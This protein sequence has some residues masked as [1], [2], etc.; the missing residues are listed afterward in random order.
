MPPLVVVGALILSLIPKF[1]ALASS[2]IQLDTF[3][4][5][6]F[7]SER[8]CSGGATNIDTV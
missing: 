6:I 4:L 5:S 8:L 1:V 3:N 2:P 7:N